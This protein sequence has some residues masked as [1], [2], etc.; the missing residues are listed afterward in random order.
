MT[1]RQRAAE[2]RDAVVR[3]GFA[4]VRLGAAAAVALIA[5]SQIAGSRAAAAARIGH[6]DEA[7]D[8]AFRFASAIS[9]DSKDR[10]RA[11]EDV[12]RATAEAG[13]FAAARE[14]ALRIDDWRRGTAL[15]D[16]AAALA[17]QGHESE[18]RDLIPLAEEVRRTTPG[19]Q[20]PRIAARMAVALALL[21]EEQRAA[22]IAG[23]LEVGDRQYG[24]VAAVTAAIAR[25]RRGDLEAG[26]RRLA[27]LDSDPD[28]DVAWSRTE[29]YL[30]I[31][32]LAAEDRAVG[33]RALRAARLSAAGLPGWRKAEGLERV[34]AAMARRD[35]AE[36]AREVVRE[37]VGIAA[38]LPPTMPVKAAILANLAGVYGALGESAGA[39]RLL[40]GAER[41]VDAAPVID[42][43][44]LY[45]RL[46]AARARVGDGPEARRLFDRALQEAASLVNARPRALAAV[47]ICRSLA[48]DV[49]PLSDPFRGRLDLL[50]AG[51]KDPW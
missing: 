38:A 4:V 33:G 46:A 37:A 20:G 1:R 21:G 16:L 15:A 24:G 10:A 36:E 45:A 17:R 27:D 2:R 51:L 35:A 43:P 6:P 28:L 42:R 25:A 49:G 30:E 11:Q 3:P 29:G 34:A 40:G 8:Y 5:A 48:L 39:R 13:L 7:L 9:A 19:W 12:V 44:G 22:A 31:D 23:G 41:E 18:A 26:M 14:R 32:R 50:F 47:E